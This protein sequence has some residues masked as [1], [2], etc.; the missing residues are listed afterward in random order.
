M[1]SFPLGPD[2]PGWYVAVKAMAPSEAIFARAQLIV[3]R[4]PCTPEWAVAHARAHLELGHHLQS[5]G[6]SDEDEDWA[7]M[8]A[9]TIHEDQAA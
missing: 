8:L 5:G 6:I 1:H 9:W 3:I 2:W 4:E 7:R